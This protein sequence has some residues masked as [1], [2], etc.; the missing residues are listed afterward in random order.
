MKKSEIRKLYLEKR[1]GLSKDEVQNL[2]EEIFNQFIFYFKPS[3]NQ[4]VHLFLPIKKLNEMDTN[5]FINYFFKNKIRVFVPKIVE[6][7]LISVELK[8]NS[9]LIE[10]LWGILEP[11]SNEDSGEKDFEFVITPLLYCDAKGNRVG[12]GKGFYDD[13][14]KSIH[15][16]TLKIGINY[17]SPQEKIDDVWKEDIPLDYLVM[18][19]EV[20]SFG[21]LESKSTK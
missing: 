12:Y 2:S 11:E 13:F 6:N 16:K 9:V 10:N 17:F 4:L 8:E 20:L 5:I 19:T 3:E 7:K 14:F 1:K 15:S 18:P 21:N